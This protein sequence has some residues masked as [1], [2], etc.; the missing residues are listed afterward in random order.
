MLPMLLIALSGCTPQPR[1]I[2]PAEW[3][4]IQAYADPMTDILLGAIQTHSYQKFSVDFDVIF[5]RVMA[6]SNFEEMLKTLDTRIGPCTQKQFIQAAETNG[7]ISVTYRLACAKDPE[8]KLQVVFS[9]DEPH[10]IGG[11][12]FDSPALQK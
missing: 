4:A 10:Q 2:P 5:R 1:Q 3:P 9:P 12:F 7:Q 11:V 8:V 6:E